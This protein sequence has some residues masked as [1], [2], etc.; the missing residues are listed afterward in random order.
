MSARPKA[1]RPGTTPPAADEVRERFERLLA[2]GIALASERT[3]AGVL[4]RVVD[5]ARDV[6][7]ARFAAL[8]VIGDDG[9]SL[10]TFEV[11]GITAD[12]RTAIG[13]PPVGQGLLGVMLQQGQP[14]RISN[15]AEHPLRQGF[16]ANH[17]PMT[18]FLGVPIVGHSRVLGNLYMTDKIDADGFSEEDERIAVLLAGQAAAAIEST[19]LFEETAA[20]LEQVQSMQR[21]R[22][23]FF[24]M[25]NHE[26]RNA[27]TGVFGWAEQLVRTKSAAATSRAGREVF[28]A[29]ERTITL[30]NNLL[31]LSR[32]DASKVQAVFKDTQLD[33]VIGKVIA[34]VQPSADAKQIELKV[35]LPYPAPVVRTDG[36]RLGQIVHNLITNALRHSASGEVVRVKVE[37]TTDEMRIMVIDRGPG[38]PHEDQARIFEPFIRHDP[39]SGLGSGLGLPVSRRLAELLGGR[40]TVHS[41]LGAG[42]TFTVA[43]PRKPPG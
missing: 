13:A 36:L 31:D 27:L 2:A 41:V 29:A 11:S 3:L 17:P 33:D 10:V 42:A 25:I 26:L 12:Q 6:V 40:L 37:P 9:R 34:T 23:Q 30:M 35:E 14:L 8:G 16:P 32:L 39:E 24:A 20:L 21:Q 15:I 19:R 7:G 28:E 4:R 22:D 5:S 18:S 38:I 1:D 43:L